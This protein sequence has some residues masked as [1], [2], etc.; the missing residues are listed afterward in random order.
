M[1][2]QKHWQVQGLGAHPAPPPTPHT[3]RGPMIFYAQNA[4][5]SLFFSN[6]SLILIEIWPKMLKITLTSTYQVR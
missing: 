1:Q 4:N 3:G 5:F 6:V 2:H